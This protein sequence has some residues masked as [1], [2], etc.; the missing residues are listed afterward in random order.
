MRDERLATV[1]GYSGARFG[2]NLM[3]VR[4][5]RLVVFL[6]VVAGMCAISAAGQQ[7]PE[8]AGDYLGSLGP[9]HLKLHLLQAPDGSLSGTLD[10]LDQGAIGLQ[11]ADF[12]F[13][14]STLSFT[15]PIVHGSW[16]GTVKG[17]AP[18]LS[19]TWDQGS[20]MPLDFTRDNF[21]PAA[22]P[23]PVDGIWLGNLQEGKDTLRIQVTVKGDREGKEFCSL[24]S[25]DQNAMGIECTNALLK[26]SDFG[27]EVP[28]V[29]GH[30]AGKLSADG[31]SLDGT[32]TQG[33]ERPLNFVRQAVA[34]ALKP[35][36]PRVYDPAMAPV[37]AAD[38]QT[39][40]TK[41][42]EGALKSG[43]LAP[44]TG[45]GVSIGVIDSRG[46][47]VFCFGTAKADSIFEIGSISKTFTGLILA[48]MI[49]QGEVKLDEPVRE[50][51]PPGTVAKP[52]GAEITL[53]D[54][55]T[56]HSGLPRMPD[57]FHPK[58]NENPYADYNAAEL[59]AF[60][61]KHGVAKAADAPYLYSNLGFGLLGQALADRAGVPYPTLLKQEVTDPLGLKDTAINLSPD[62]QRRFIPGHDA[63]HRPA[64]AWDLVAFAGAGAIRSTAGDMLT[65]VEANLRPESVKAT[66]AD[67]RTLAR[68]PWEPRTSCAPTPLE[69]NGSPS[70]GIM[71]RTAGIIGTTARPGAIVPTRS[72]IR[73]PAMPPSFC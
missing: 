35:V 8:I 40:L 72:S 55:V 59:Y 19:G 56:Q 66:G 63:K 12:H 7:K 5:L 45:A 51:L 71:S 10:S 33:E 54:L 68:R 52:R 60:V 18:T 67:G 50:L 62:Q 44:E 70:P 42:L 26:G 20:P 73:K 46:R 43:E 29:T 22:K 53:L 64:H 21:V 61:A 30:W 1:S 9:L 28:A 48:Q 14:G 15:V 23:S 49:A 24:D 69:V 27:F 38:L 4:C 13:D 16:K 47:A 25:L 39:V 58:D 37:A 17:A 32:W 36:P 57:N 41:D 11:C 3:G 6:W 31:N 34:L 2:A 65:Y